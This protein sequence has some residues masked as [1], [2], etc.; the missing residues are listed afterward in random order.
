MRVII[1]ALAKLGLV[2]GLA[3]FPGLLPFAAARAGEI[4]P[5]ACNVA[6]AAFMAITSSQ[7]SAYPKDMGASSRS[8]GRL[9]PVVT[10]FVGH[11]RL[12]KDEQSDLI[13]QQDKYSTEHFAPG[14]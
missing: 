2:V 3:I 6:Q 4:H 11:M 1:S 12:G 7:D 9:K 13:S 8:F 14:C 5:E 10:S